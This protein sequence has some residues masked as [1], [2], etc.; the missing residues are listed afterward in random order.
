MDV[1][2]ITVTVGGMQAISQSLLAIVEPGDEVLVPVPVWPNILQAVQIAGGRAVPLTMQFSQEG[3]WQLDLDTIAGA[4]TNKT[5]A[6]FI[7]SPSNPTGWV[8]P[9]ADV[10][11]LL[12]MCRQRGIWIIADEVYGRLVYPTDQPSAAVAPVAP[13]FL[14]IAAPED[15]VIVTN[16][17][18]KNWSM[19]GWRVGWVVAPPSLGLVFDNLMQY[20]STG[21]T[22][23]A[24]HAS[25]VALDQGDQQID[26]MVDQCRTGRDIVCDR[27]ATLPNIE[28][29]R[30]RGAFYLFFRVAGLT[31]S[32]QLAF[33]LLDA[34]GVG[35]APGAGFHPS[36]EGWMRLC[37]GVSH[38]LLRDAADR[39]VNYL[40][41]RT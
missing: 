15:Q 17:M 21:A 32:R 20:G 24:Q 23:F 33:D 41:S 27:L 26:I 34:T 11:A 36:G 8:M 31:D 12:S 14:P 1:E 9:A 7:N 30:P 35:L 18:S 3:G 19:T 22:T 38:P 2:R 5:R 39:I 40:K 16:T 13:S 37:F 10:S 6:I 29:A 4:I 25:V 28:F